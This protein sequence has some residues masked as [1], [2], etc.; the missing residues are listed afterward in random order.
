MALC[1]D[2]KP[3]KNLKL[4]LVIAFKFLLKA[5]KMKWPRWFREY[6]TLYANNLLSSFGLYSLL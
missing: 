3:R 1:E 2:L 5:S 4:L 6:L